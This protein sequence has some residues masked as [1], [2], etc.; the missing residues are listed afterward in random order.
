[1]VLT[2]KE[3]FNKR[4]ELPK[5]TSNSIEDI[6]KL[7]NIKKSILQEVYNRGI[8]AYKTNPSSVRPQVKSKEMWAMARIYSFVNK[9]ESNKGLNH[10]IDLLLKL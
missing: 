2:H 8:G 6:S 7:S 1:M 9:I 5:G 3:Q 10:D 4:H